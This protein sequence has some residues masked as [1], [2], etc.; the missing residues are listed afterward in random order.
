MRKIAV[1]ILIFMIFFGRKW[2]TVV[3]AES[4]TTENKKIAYISN[5][6]ELLS[7]TF[8]SE[9][10]PQK[11]EERAFCNYTLVLTKDLDVHT[12]TSWHEYVEDWETNGW[13]ARSTFASIEGGG[14]TIYN[15]WALPALNN[16]GR[17]KVSFLD[18]IAD[19]FVRNL[20]IIYD[21]S[22]MVQK[23][24][25]SPHD[26]DSYY[27][28]YGGL[29]I[30]C[31]NALISNV[32]VQGNFFLAASAGGIV[33]KSAASSIKNCSFEGELMGANVGGIG[34]ISDN[35]SVINC[36][37]KGTIIA[38]GGG[39]LIYRP[40]SGGSPTEFTN[41]VVMITDFQ[42]IDFGFSDSDFPPMG[43]FFGNYSENVG[44][45]ILLRDNYV[46]NI[47]GYPQA[48]LDAC[49]GPR[50]PLNFPPEEVMGLND[51]SDFLV[52]SNFSGLDY[53]KFWYMDADSG[54]PL[55]KRNFISI[56]NLSDQKFADNFIIRT[57]ERFYNT[58]EIGKVEA[59][60]RNKDLCQLI[61]FTLDGIDVLDN[62]L[63]NSLPL[64]MSS[65]HV[66]V[67][68]AECLGIVEFKN[69]DQVKT[70]I[71][72][73]SKETV[74]SQNFQVNYRLGEELRFSFVLAEN[75]ELE[76]IKVDGNYVLGEEDG[77]YTLT[78]PHRSS[79]NL[80]DKI[81]V[82]FYT[83]MREEKTNVP[84][85]KPEKT[86]L[87]ILSGLAA[88]LIF[89]LIFFKKKIFKINVKGGK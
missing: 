52:A 37:F 74:K 73:D 3:T 76:D 22:K 11:I 5:L 17:S 53:T 83:K 78:I 27:G 25:T 2:T 85:K 44:E 21:D 59:K 9:A 47:D 31:N 33:T 79:F 54:H 60:I 6:G 68:K 24:E 81:A 30:E 63:P 71:I 45:H 23:P 32:H 61:Y 89:S 38:C 48:S 1:F 15:L 62:L 28:D 69:L 4:K 87:P 39:G 80:P 51:I 7:Y 84:D 65:N 55:L 16:E 40:R 88:C 82:E 46:L 72:N 70:L 56:I 43:S 19:N 64:F 36:F 13:Y 8:D 18:T 75:C 86:L 49:S 41:N 10:E 34:V 67:V 26:R 29:A 20:N 14:H 35:T 12:D 58:N 42:T 77:V 50:E 66:I 57:E